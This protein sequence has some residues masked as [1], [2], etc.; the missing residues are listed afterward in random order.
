MSIESLISRYNP[1]YLERAKP[2]PD[3][4]AL[5]TIDDVTLDVTSAA[6]WDVTAKDLPMNEAD[7][8]P[9]YGWSSAKFIDA[10]V[11][12]IAC[13]VFV[14]QSMV[15]RNG[16]KSRLVLASTSGLPAGC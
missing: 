11:L 8:P 10:C 6:P 1:N 5:D 3:N 12:I 13:D 4:V 9:L 2:C 15:R 16:S 14:A 7:L